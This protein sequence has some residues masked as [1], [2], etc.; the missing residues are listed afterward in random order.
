VK[1]ELVETR[2]SIRRT[3]PDEYLF[4]GGTPGLW[5]ADCIAEVIA[6]RARAVSAP[7]PTPSK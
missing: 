7:P 1:R 6:A 5:R 4:G 2:A 3:A